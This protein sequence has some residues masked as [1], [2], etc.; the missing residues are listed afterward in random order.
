MFRRQILCALLLIKGRNAAAWSGSSSESSWLVWSALGLGHTTSQ[1]SS[2]CSDLIMLWLRRTR[3]LWTLVQLRHRTTQRTPPR[4]AI[5][6]QYSYQMY[7]YMRMQ[8]HYT[9]NIPYGQSSAKLPVTWSLGHSVT[10]SL[11]HLVTWS[12]GHLVTW[13]L[14]HSVTRSLGHSVTRSLGHLV[15]WSLG[16]LVTWSLG[17]LVTWSLG[18]SVTWSLGHSVI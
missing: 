2:E 16:H 10:Q 9:Q 5:R 15:T 13:S 17:H 7:Q 11:G 8:I 3:A 1:E 12:L 18:H 14:G 6:H 4:R